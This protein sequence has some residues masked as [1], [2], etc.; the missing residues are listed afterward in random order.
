MFSHTRTWTT[1]EKVLFRFCCLFFSLNILPIPY[2]D[3]WLTPVVGRWFLGIEQLPASINN[4]S[5][6]SLWSWVWA[7]ALLLVSVIGTLI[8]SLADRHRS[9][10]NKAKYVLDTLVLYFLI[11]NMLTYG[12]AKIVAQQMP[13]P[14]DGRL[15][16]RVGDMSPMGMLWTFIGSST[17][18]QVFCGSVRYQSIAFARFVGHR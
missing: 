9:S 4:G 6:D 8:W 12:V 17:P 14:T 5:G 18:Y 11:I 3:E 2:L 13:F 15:W 1:A 7:F 16:Q 10:Y